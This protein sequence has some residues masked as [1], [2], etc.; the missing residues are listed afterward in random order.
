MSK[1]KFTGF[2]DEYFRYKSED[3]EEGKIKVSNSDKPFLQ[4]YRSVLNSKSTEDSMVNKLRISPFC[5]W[6]SATNFFALFMSSPPPYVHIYLY[7]IKDTSTII[8][9]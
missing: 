2:G 7:R 6:M 3:D 1:K 4:G 5:L 9:N 8:L